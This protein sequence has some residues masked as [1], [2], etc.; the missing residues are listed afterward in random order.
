MKPTL[1]AKAMLFWAAVLVGCGG[2]G[3]PGGAP[4]PNAH[5]NGSWHAALTSPTSG[6]NSSVDVFILQNGT[7]LTS[8][9]VFMGTTCSSVGTMSGTVSGNTI[10]MSITG[11]EGDTISF[12]GTVS[13]DNSFSG[14][15]ATKTS[16]QCSLND[17]MGSLSATLIPSVQS[18]SWTGKTESTQYPPGNTTF[19]ANLTE[20]TS[21]NI[22]GM[23]TFTTSSGS[24]A[25]CPSLATGPVTGYQIGSS[26][27]LTDNQ[28]DGLGLGG[29]I[30][31]T[32]KNISGSYFISICSGD[33]G[34]VTMSRP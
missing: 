17:D 18:A 28:A 31:S 26:M 8:N 9:Q 3:S 23:L 32:A 22:T 1:A 20:D 11:N 5:L 24:S 25:S 33:N 4:T 12:T 2:S 30:D 19:T 13:S 16:G 14:S 7:A 6:I 21:G 15:Y 34:N 10:Q 27:S 29:T